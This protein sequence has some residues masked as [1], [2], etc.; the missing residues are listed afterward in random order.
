[1]A[2]SL[3]TSRSL[4]TLHLGCEHGGGHADGGTGELLERGGAYD[5]RVGV[6]GGQGRCRVDACEGRADGWNGNLAGLAGNT[7]GEAGAR[8][9]AEALKT[10]RFL[11][12]LVLK[13]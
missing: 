6:P 10:N 12:M 9:V 2:D 11:E 1:V 8:A 3:E 5:G 13:G 7:I 4:R